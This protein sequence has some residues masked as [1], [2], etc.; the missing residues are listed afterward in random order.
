MES[1]WENRPL[2]YSIVTSLAVVF[3]LATGVMPD[4]NEQFSVVMFPQDVS[5]ATDPTPLTPVLPI[6]LSRHRLT[7]VLT[8]ADP[9]TDPCPDTG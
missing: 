8:L 7:P 3:T 9:C 4:L 1:L 2:L 6:T 5:T